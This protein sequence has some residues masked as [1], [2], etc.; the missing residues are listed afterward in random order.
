MLKNNSRCGERG[1]K[2]DEK[3]ERRLKHENF[4]RER[5]PPTDRRQEL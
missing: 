5:D 3:M 4:R 1:R 2:E